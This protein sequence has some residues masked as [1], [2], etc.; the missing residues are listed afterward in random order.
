VSTIREEVAEASLK[1]HMDAR[2]GP[3]RGTVNYRHLFGLMDELGYAGWV[4]CEYRP[5]GRT[6]DGLQWLNLW[7]HGRHIA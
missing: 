7:R 3:A 6:E 4:G 1:V 2:S 5:G